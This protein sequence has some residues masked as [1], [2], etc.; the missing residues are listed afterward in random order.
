MT[1]MTMFTSKFFENMLDRII[2][3]NARLKRMVQVEIFKGP[4]VVELVLRDG[5]RITLAFLGHPQKDDEILTAVAYKE[6]SE[7]LHVVCVPYAEIVRVEAFEPEKKDR[8][9]IG[10][11]A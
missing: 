2:E 5:S 10:F 9:T 8:T 4:P 3:E 11:K 6:K 1:E 7:D